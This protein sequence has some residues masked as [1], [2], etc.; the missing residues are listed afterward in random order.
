MAGSLAPQAKLFWVTTTPVPTNPP[1]DPATGK[2][3]QL[4]P[5]RIESDVVVRV[6]LQ[7]RLGG[8]VRPK[9]SPKK[10][11]AAACL[12]LCHCCC[13]TVGLPRPIMTLHW[14]SCRVAASLMESATCTKSSMTTAVK[15]VLRAAGAGSVIGPALTCGCRRQEVDCPDEQYVC[16]CVLRRRSLAGT[17]PVTLPSAAALISLAMVSRCSGTPLL[18]AFSRRDSRFSRALKSHGSIPFQQSIK[19]GVIFFF[20]SPP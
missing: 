5:G 9:K 14:L 11:D 3:C 8:A 6:Q 12:I 2:S 15:G 1:P 4:L 13:V 19:C 18:R 17:A 10:S 20:F 7:R 16:V